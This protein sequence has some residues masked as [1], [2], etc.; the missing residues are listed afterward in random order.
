MLPDA[1]ASARNRRLNGEKAQWQY[2]HDGATTA[3][4]NSKY[5]ETWTTKDFWLRNRVNS[6]DKDLLW[7]NCLQRGARTDGT[8]ASSPATRSDCVS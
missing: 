8:P 1:E 5:V 7:V 4:V 6:T 2:A 3:V